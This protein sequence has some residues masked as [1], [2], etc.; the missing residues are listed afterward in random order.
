MANRNWVKDFLEASPWALGA[1]AFGAVLTFVMTAAETGLRVYERVT[2]TAPTPTREIVETSGFL[3]V[4]VTKEMEDVPLVRNAQ[5]F[6]ALFKE[7]DPKRLPLWP[8]RLLVLNPT[9]E[10]INLHTC[11]MAVSLPPA[12]L[13]GVKFP[14]GRAEST[15]YFLSDTLPPKA[16]AADEPILVEPTKAKHVRLFFLFPLLDHLKEKPQTDVERLKSWF[17]SP[18]TAE[19]TCRDTAKRELRATATIFERI[20]PHA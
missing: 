5:K 12:L 8:M 3:L 1:V 13:S 7:S 4:S 6:T 19:I 14:S 9:K 16:Q 15:L 17:D 11:R 2:S 20:T 10:S 18:V